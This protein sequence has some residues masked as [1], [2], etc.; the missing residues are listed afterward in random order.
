MTHGKHIFNTASDT[1]IATMCAYLSTKYVWPHWKCALRC[2]AKCPRIDLPSLESYH[3]NTNFSPTMRFHVYHLT[4]RYI[5]HDR[6]PFNEKKDCK[7]CEAYSDS[8]LTAKIYTTKDIFVM[9]TSIVDFR[10]NFYV[11]A[12]KK[13]AFKLTHVH[14]LGT[15]HCGNKGQEAFKRHEYYQDVLC[16]WNYAEHLLAI[17]VHQIQSKYYGGNRYVSIKGIVLEKFSDTYQWTSSSSLYSC[18][19]HVLFNCFC[20]VTA[21]N[22]QLQHMRIAKHHRFVET[23]T[24]G[25]LNGISTIWDNID[26]CVKHCICATEIYLLSILL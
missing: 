9:E 21:K 15:H 24:T 20:W 8:K 1:A 25:F 6:R 22:M 3:N 16:R 2:C 23:Q 19:R 18:K 10:Q 26:G 7:L 14:N 4:A 13:L 5:V 17:F 12:I 11:H